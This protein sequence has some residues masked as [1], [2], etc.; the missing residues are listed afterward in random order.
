M[1]FHVK[2]SSAR[3]ATAAG[4]TGGSAAGEAH[5]LLP[6]AGGRGIP[7]RP[8]AGAQHRGSVAGEAEEPKW[9][10]RRFLE[11]LGLKW[12]EIHKETSF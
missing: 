10:G 5:G 2:A 4:A 12:P 11:L 6:G 8:V 1:A 7:Q 9:Q 3:E